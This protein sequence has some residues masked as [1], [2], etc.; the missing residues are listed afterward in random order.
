MCSCLQKNWKYV[1]A[2]PEAGAIPV[3]MRIAIPDVS[4]FFLNFLILLPIPVCLPSL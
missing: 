2:G 3:Q 4:I 1:N